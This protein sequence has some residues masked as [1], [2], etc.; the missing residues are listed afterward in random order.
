M[1]IATGWLDPSVS[2]PRTGQ[3]L[4]NT[5][6]MTG[7]AAFLLAPTFDCNGYSSPDHTDL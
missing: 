3:R 5:T 7:G 1:S 6:V 2:G 4:W